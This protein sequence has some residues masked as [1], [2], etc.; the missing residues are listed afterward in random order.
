MHNNVFKNVWFVCVRDYLTLIHHFV[1]IRFPENY[2]DAR[3]KAVQGTV[4]SNLESDEEL[5]VRSRK[6]TARYVDS[7]M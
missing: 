6:R 4:T 1:I 3:Q 2:K 5:I 7:G